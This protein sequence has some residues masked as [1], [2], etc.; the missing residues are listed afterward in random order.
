MGTHKTKLSD[1]SDKKA[2]NLKILIAEDDEVS[3]V[4]LSIL[5][6]EYSSEILIARN[7]IEAVEIYK[8]NPG[9]DLILM[10]IQM[11]YLN[12]YEATSQIRQLNKK[13]PLGVIK[14]FVF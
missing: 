10:D 7:G 14:L 13:N 12:G 1:K 5:V 6:E 8:N 9:I 3:S 4:Y 11:P 2:G